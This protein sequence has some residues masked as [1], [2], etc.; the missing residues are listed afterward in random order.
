MDM[1]DYPIEYR[2]PMEEEKLILLGII[3]IVL[4]GIVFAMNV[5]KSRGHGRPYQTFPPSVRH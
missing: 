1:L 3:S 2:R 4:I 5:C